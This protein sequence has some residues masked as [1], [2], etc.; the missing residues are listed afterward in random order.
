[1]WVY[2]CMHISY[3]MHYKLYIDI[4]T[5]I[6]RCMWKRNECSG[7]RLGQSKGSGEEGRDAG[8]EG[9]RRP[10]RAEGPWLTGRPP[11][12]GACGTW[13]GRDVGTPEGRGCGRRGESAAP[14]RLKTKHRKGSASKPLRIGWRLHFRDL[15][16]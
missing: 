7:Q 5:Y 14:Q 1:M 2:P 13:T 9:W 6:H 15:P 4:Y 12:D 3:T 16:D 8:G 10:W 11:E